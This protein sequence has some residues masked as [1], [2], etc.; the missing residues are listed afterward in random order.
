MKRR[1]QQS[2][3]VGLVYLNVAT[4]FYVF[5]VRAMWLYMV[6]AVLVGIAVAELWP[7]APAE[8]WLERTLPLLG[9][10]VRVTL[11]RPEGEAAVVTNGTLLAFGD[12]GTLVIVQED[13][14]V[15]YAWPLLDIEPL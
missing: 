7:E 6:T 3:V 11:D 13:G 15:H 5:G 10:Q 12:D 9:K 4:I 2:A 14:F 1:L 8:S